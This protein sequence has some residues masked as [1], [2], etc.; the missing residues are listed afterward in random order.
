MRA[1]TKLRNVM[2][3]WFE[4]LATGDTAWVERH[5]SRRAGVRLVG[6]DPAEWQ[7]GWNVAA[8][9]KEAVKA[10][11]GVIQVWS[12]EIEAYDE[13]SVGWGL[14][15]PVATMPNGQQIALRWS[16]VFHREDGE[17]R[18]VQLHAS[19]GVPN[20][21]WSGSGTADEATAVARPPTR[22]PPSP[23]H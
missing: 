4:S 8:F 18:L 16:A 19:V 14:A 13:G 21:A 22:R 6:V 1:S 23:D 15:R 9:L 2:E 10:L 3:G 5:V 12:G 20:E 11:D 17:W 7:E